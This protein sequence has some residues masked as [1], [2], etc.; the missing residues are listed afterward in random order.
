MYAC[1]DLGSN[2]FHLLIAEKRKGKVLLIERCSDKVQIGEGVQVTGQISPAAFERGLQSLRHFQ[3]LIALH[4]VKR[5]WA[6]GTNTFRTADNADAFIQAAA[7]IGIQISVISGVQEAVLIY[8]GVIS[9]LPTT[10][11]KRLV[12]D[13]GGGSTEVI[14]GK[15]HKRLITHSLPVGC[16]AWRDRYFSSSGPFEVLDKRLDEAT[17]AARKIFKAVAPGVNKYD[18]VEA[19][20]SSGTAKMLAAVCQGQ[21]FATGEISQLALS[22]LRDLMV[23]AI[24]EGQELPGLKDK[25]RDLLL[26]GCAVMLGLMAAFKCDVI[27]F[28]PA[29]L[30]EGM[31]EFMVKN[32]QTLKAVKHD[33]MPKVNVSA[34]P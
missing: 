24:A 16:V 10:S 27:R 33:A 8:A 6:L 14:I 12:I 26:P 28:S 19:Y 30:R 2:S 15:K 13:I 7:D 34:G 9:A 1:I 31:L 3:S 20:A 4:A 11:N 22:S 18:W 29:A 5:Y 17:E 23:Q 21:G 32:R 25:R